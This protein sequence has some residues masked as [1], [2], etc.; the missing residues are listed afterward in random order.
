M[1]TRK[2]DVWLLLGL[3]GLLPCSLLMAQT[4]RPGSLE[5]Q[6]TQIVTTYENAL[7][8][9]AKRQT[10]TLTRHVMVDSGDSRERYWAEA[11]TYVSDGHRNRTSY[12]RSHPGN[13]VSGKFDLAT[14]TENLW[15]GERILNYQKGG[16]A[17]MVHVTPSEEVKRAFGDDPASMMARGVPAEGVF[18]GFFPCEAKPINEIIR[19]CRDV[20]VENGEVDDRKC[21]LIRARDVGGEYKVWFDAEHYGILRAEVTKQG[22]DDFFGAPLSKAPP[23]TPDG[24]GA[25]VRFAKDVPLPPISPKANYSYTLEN[26]RFAIK[27]GLSVP[28]AA[29]SVETLRYKNGRIL[30][31]R[32]THEREKIDLRPSLSEKTFTLDIPNNTIATPRSGTS[33]VHYVWKNGQAVPS[34]NQGTVHAIE[35]VAQQGRLRPPT[36]GEE[37]S[38]IWW[39]ALFAVF[40]IGTVT[41]ALVWRRLHRQ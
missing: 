14:E 36:Y 18:S 27:D 26:V 29:S 21:F 22:N 2:T 5:A 30:S 3:A 35:A 13:N 10:Q 28:V 24:P 7:T 1:S 20:T 6:A 31:S 41:A 12:R 11:A 19:G 33:T 8:A 37:I 9:V 34:V 25:P 38:L 32:H 15:D 23:G 40:G 17:P 4:S 39:Q 16:R